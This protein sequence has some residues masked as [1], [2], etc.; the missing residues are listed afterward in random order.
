MFW[1]SSGT[2]LLK[3]DTARLAASSESNSTKQKPFGIDTLSSVSIA[4]PS[5]C[6]TSPLVYLNVGN[7]TLRIS[8][9]LAKILAMCSRVRL[10]GKFST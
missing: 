6:A 4:A 7:V 10:S 9:A 8:P 3:V 2:Q 1:N 5:A